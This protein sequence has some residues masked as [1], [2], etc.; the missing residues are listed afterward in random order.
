MSFDTKLV[1][2]FGKE[3][4]EKIRSVLDNPE[5][6]LE[7]PTAR[8]YYNACHHKPKTSE[9]LMYA[10]NEILEGYG[11]EG[12]TNPENMNDGFDYVNMGD[13]YAITITRRNGYRVESYGDRIGKLGW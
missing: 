10:F 5:S 7:Y 8:A 13:T 9:L 2:N 11:I 1:D 4:A 6:V 12:I 3:K